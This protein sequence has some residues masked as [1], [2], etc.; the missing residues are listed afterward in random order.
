[1]GLFLSM[2]HYHS[3][4]LECLY[5]VEDQHYTEND[6]VCPVCGIANFTEPA[7][8]PSVNEQ[9]FF[10]SFLAEVEKLFLSAQP[11]LQ[12]STRAPPLVA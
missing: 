1:M 11:I 7:S 3:E 8:T 2:A 4:G 10:E 9:L 12:H 5:H 6:L